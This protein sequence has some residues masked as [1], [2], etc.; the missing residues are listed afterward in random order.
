MNIK[1]KE[2][3]PKMDWKTLFQGVFAGCLLWGFMFFAFSVAEPAAERA[4]LEARYYD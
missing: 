2:E 1:Y 4:Y 3:M